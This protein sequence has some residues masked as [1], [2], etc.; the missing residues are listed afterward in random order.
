ME[1]RDLFAGEPIALALHQAVEAAILSIGPAQIRVSKSQVGF[2]RKHPFASTWRP[3]QYLKRKA[4]PLVLS[5]YL[6]RRDRSTRWKEVV[7]PTPGRFTH[8]LELHK[9]A[10]VDEFVRARLIEAWKHAA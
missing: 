6:G 1:V 10:D 7:E 2:Y 4:A 5:I 8:H 9:V 3:G